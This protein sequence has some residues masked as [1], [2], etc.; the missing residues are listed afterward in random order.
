MYNYI[1]QFALSCRF[2]PTSLSL[3]DKVSREQ[4]P[5]QA[6]HYF[7]GTKVLI[8]QILP[9]YLKFPNGTIE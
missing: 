1:T 9:S 6:Y 8:A 7:F 2:V 3:V 5:K 4:A